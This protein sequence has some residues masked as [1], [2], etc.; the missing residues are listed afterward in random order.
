MSV[1]LYPRTGKMQDALATLRGFAVGKPVVVEETFPLRCSADELRTLIEASRGVVSGWI[2]FYWGKTPA[3]CRASGQI[4]DALVLANAA[5]LVLLGGTLIAG[6]V[7]ALVHFD[8]AGPA[9][10]RVAPDAV[11]PA[12]RPGA[13]PRADAA[14]PSVAMVVARF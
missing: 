5:S 2:G 12:L 4:A 7:D 10:R 8:P 11:P 13:A 6:V 1:H 9:W 14:V 3:E